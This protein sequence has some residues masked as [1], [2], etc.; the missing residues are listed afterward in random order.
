MTECYRASLL[1]P[2]VKRCKVDVNFDGGEISSDGGMLL[3]RELDKRLGLTTA[4]DHV[5]HDN[6]V[7]G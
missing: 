1:F 5:L 2:P 4:I 3:L 6:R 7:Q